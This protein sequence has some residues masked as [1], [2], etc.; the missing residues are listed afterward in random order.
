MESLYRE[1]SRNWM[2]D[3]IERI[4]ID[5]L[6]EFMNAYKTITVSIGFIHS[7]EFK[8]AIGDIYK[9]IEDSNSVTRA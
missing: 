5:A 4:F 8:K 3:R 7:K 6:R 1:E 2:N 9:V